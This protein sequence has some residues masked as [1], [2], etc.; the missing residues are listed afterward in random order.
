MCKIR[1][2]L[3]TGAAGGMGRAV[4]RALAAD[5]WFVFAL[6]LTPREREENILP[7][8]ADL[9]DEESVREAYAKVAAVTDRLDAV[10]HFAGTYMLDSLVEMESAAFDKIL[11]VNLYSAYFVNKTFLPM[12]KNGTKVLMTT[13][14]LAPLDPLPFTGVYAVTKGA[15]DK[16]AYSLR[17]E[18]Q[19]L[20]ISVSVLRAGAV[21]TGMLGA[22]VA[23]LDTFCEKT[24]HYRT[25]A[26]R[27]HDIVD[28][29]E[30]KSVPPEAVAKKV[31]KILA[32][33]HP[34]FAYSINRNPALR[35]LSLLP[36]R[37]QCAIIR[38]ILKG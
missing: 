9:T 18:L 21:K 14:E 4:S 24:E 16:Y 28:R 11:R 17:M 3:V 10:L 38:K 25:G 8:T 31:R 15:L 20:G 35:L 34:A 12:M 32:K 19:L 27:F 30:A 5:G 23:A 33:K 22:S 13:S 37:L 2:A 26:K 36:K 29:V 6:D 7:I 1:Y